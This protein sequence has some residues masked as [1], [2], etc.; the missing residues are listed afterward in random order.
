V[1]D[2]FFFFLRPVLPSPA[3]S[4]ALR[5]PASSAH[6]DPP[7]TAFGA[8]PRVVLFFALAFCAMALTC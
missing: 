1:L 6:G 7:P 5:F 3:S 4:G 2:L 8:S